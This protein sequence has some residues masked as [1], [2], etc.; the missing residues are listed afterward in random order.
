[1]ASKEPPS[2]RN[3]SYRQA[4]FQVPHEMAR[5]NADAPRFRV[6]AVSPMPPLNKTFREMREMGAPAPAPFDPEK[7]SR[8]F[9][10]FP[11]DATRATAAF[12]AINTEFRPVEERAPDGRVAVTTNEKH[13]RLNMAAANIWICQAVNW[14]RHHPHVLDLIEPGPL[15]VIVTFRE[16]ACEHL[17]D[18]TTENF[19][20]LDKDRE[21]MKLTILTQ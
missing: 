2:R 6:E 8:V 5:L 18:T 13:L 14:R 10:Y 11:N 3:Q 20:N 19:L 21:L 17:W 12:V 7:E 15:P 4:S 1:M 16:W 9:L